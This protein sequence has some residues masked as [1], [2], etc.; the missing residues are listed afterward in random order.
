MFLQRRVQFYSEY[1]IFIN[2]YRLNLFCTEE[3]SILLLLTSCFLFIRAPAKE[4][5]VKNESLEKLE[6]SLQFIPTYSYL[7][8]KPQ[9]IGCPRGRYWAKLQSNSDTKTARS[10]PVRCLW[11]KREFAARGGRGKRQPNTTPTAPS[12]VQMCWGQRTQRDAL[13]IVSFKR[14]FSKLVLH[15]YLQFQW[16]SSWEIHRNSGF[17]SRLGHPAPRSSRA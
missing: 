12:S 17:G 13:S 3:I 8:C 2:V 7:L 5:E 16:E 4:A 14:A 10:L 1:F 15:K 9:H 11:R 6:R